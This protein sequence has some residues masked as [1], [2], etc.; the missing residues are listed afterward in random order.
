MAILKHLSSKSAN[1]GRAL[2]Y[3]MYE[4]DRLT[5][6]SK[7]NENGDLIMRDSFLIDSLDCNVATFDFEC[8]ELNKKYNKNYAYNDIKSHHYIISFDPADSK[9]SL[10]TLKDAQ[11][12]GMDYARRNFAGHQTL[13]CTHSDGDHGSGNMHVHIIIN[14]LR[15]RDVPREEFMERKI[16]NR[17]GYKHH[18]TRGY[19]KYLKEDLMNVCEKENLHQ[20]DLLSPAKK[21]VTDREYWA[22]ERGNEL[23]ESKF[24]LV[25]DKIR[26]AI[27]DASSRCNSEKGFAHILKSEH[28]ITLKISRGRYSYVLPNREKAIRGRTLGTD[29]TEQTL[30]KKFLDNAKGKNSNKQK[31]I[32]KKKVSNLEPIDS[33]RVKGVRYPKAFTMDTDLPIVRDL[34]VYAMK[35]YNL[36]SELGYSVDD[37][38]SLNDTILY[39]QKHRI[40]NMGAFEEDYSNQIGKELSASSA[41]KDNEIKLKEIN[42]QI[43]YTRQYSKY[44][45]I[46]KQYMNARNKNKFRNEHETELI[47]FEVAHNYFKNRFEDGT[48]PSYAHINS[49]RGKIVDL[50]KLLK[51]RSRL[52]KDQVPLRSQWEKESSTQKQ[53]RNMK[54]NLYDIF[55]QPSLTKERNRS[56]DMSL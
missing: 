24:E 22:K 20:V 34:Q 49:S 46:Y 2:E 45:G 16:D 35:S 23:N 30:R 28:N 29:Y 12:I 21:K 27:E 33:Y 44:K 6:R 54:K 48:L 25:K 38:R 51:I 47:H 39:L 3:L 53:L 56:F 36:S 7:A 26:N 55:K 31:T 15:K 32:V 10:L 40:K 13:V 5:N 9:E 42:E 19:L 52:T 41:L 11:R 17:A 43:K 1:Y 18:L 50:D 8:E 37:Y 14:S 4:Q